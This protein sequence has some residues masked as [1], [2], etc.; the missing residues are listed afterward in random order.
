METEEQLLGIASD[1][2][3]PLP[4]PPTPGGQGP[5]MSTITVMTPSM[6]YSILLSEGIKSPETGD[7]SE[8]PNNL[9]EVK[10]AIA[11]ATRRLKQS[12][13]TMT[14]VD[15]YKSSM[16]ATLTRGKYPKGLQINIPLLA[17]A[18]DAALKNT[19]EA[20][21]TNYSKNLLTSLVS[22]Y[23]AEIRMQL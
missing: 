3:S 10:Q 23:K 22:H 7:R 17:F 2:E 13:I 1:Q 12:L 20:I 6:H 18:A 21:Q 8:D 4:N 9:H 19:W 11:E 16:K 15:H 5:G 14:K